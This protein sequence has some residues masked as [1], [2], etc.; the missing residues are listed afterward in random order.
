MKVIGI[1]DN[2]VDDYTTRRAMYP[3]GNAL[4]FAVYASMLGSEAAYLGV[5]GTDVAA[6]HVRRTL[7]ELGID[8]A[9]CVVV[10]GPNGRARLQLEDGERIFL[11]SNEGGIAKSVP[12]DFVFDDPGY[13]RGFDLIHTSAYSY[14]DS[15]LARFETTGCP[16]SYDFSD[17]FDA[18]AA[19]ALCPFVDFGFFSCADRADAEATEL[20]EAAVGRGCRLAVAT[21]GDRDAIVYDGRQWYR[22]APVPVEPVDTLGAGDA[23]ITAF[24]LSHVGG[25]GIEAALG[26][27]ASFA[28]RACHVDGAFGHGLAY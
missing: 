9:H 8:T 15:Y 14:L 5:F 10:D 2:V 12:M 6:G 18:D 26:N 7:D 20:L 28:A 27:A 17:D 13:L 21:R 23:F 1:G 25:A 22:Q 4:N 16:L 24:L 3:G 11:G 19:L